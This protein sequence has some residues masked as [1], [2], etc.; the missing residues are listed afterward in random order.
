MEHYDTQTNV[1]C[2]DFKYNKKFF[3]FQ[4]VLHEK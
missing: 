4:K 3:V 1:I 2:F